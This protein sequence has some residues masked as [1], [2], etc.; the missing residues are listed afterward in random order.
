[1]TATHPE[2]LPARHAPA[3]EVSA[4]SDTAPVTGRHPSEGAGLLL[5]S[6]EDLAEAL[7]DLGF[8]VPR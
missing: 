3:G 7:L 6:A 1:M 2:L 8:R 5:R 4:D